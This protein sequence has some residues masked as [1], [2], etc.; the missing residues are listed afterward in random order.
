MKTKRRFFEFRE[1]V[2]QFRRNARFVLV[3]LVAIMV[4]NVFTP[5]ATLATAGE[6]RI[7]VHGEDVDFGE[8]NP[9]FVDGRTYVPYGFFVEILG[10]NVDLPA[11]SM[12]P[13]RSTMENLGHIIEWDSATRTAN[14]RLVAQE[15]ETANDAR[16]SA[17]AFMDRLVVN[18]AMGA[19]L[20]MSA[21]MQ[22][23]FPV[24]MVMF[25]MHGEVIDFTIVDEMQQEDLNIFIIS[26]THTKGA[27]VHS[28]VVDAN[29]EIAGVQVVD[30]SFEPRLPSAN[31]NF[32]AEAI[33]VGEGTEWYLDGLLTIPNGA[34]AQN[35]VPA[36]ILVHG[37]GGQN[38]DTSFFEN[39]P[40]AD[41]A[42]Y[43]S[44]NGI[45][46]LRYNKRTWMHSHGMQA[47]VVFGDDIT[48]W[49][50]TIEDAL[51]AAEILRAD[52]RISEVF[53]VG[54]SMGGLLAPRIAEEGDL[55]G[56]IMLAASPHP[57]FVISYNQNIHFI[58][59]A[60]AAGEISQEIADM[61]IA[62]AYAWLVEAR[63]MIT[64]PIEELAGRYIFHMPALYQRS[65][66]D[67]LP[68]P[69]I[70]GGNRPTLIIHGGRDFQASTEADFLPMVEATEGLAHVITMYFDGINHLLMQSQTDF[71][72]LRD[73][74]VQGNVDE[75][76]LRSMV[77]WIV[78]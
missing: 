49:E 55:D 24:D 73:Y 14:I 71:N 33:V 41:I 48:V 23:V 10:A 40:F 35:P 2:P 7:T 43:L 54:H 34:S 25:G 78:R 16:A 39:R 50:E 57:L 61:H 63:E 15:I 72:D 32:A 17:T 59:E 22:Q 69:I 31:A 4:V 26:A 5:L 18:D 29:G 21:E 53:V 74:H 51:L 75:N 38:M 70:I 11:L 27:A 67:S 76:I 44:S 8:E 45:A 62:A 56:V 68:L 9:M 42:E 20:M 6:I 19:A 30:F 64:W 3:M 60:L 66:Y 47:A 52:E 1:I 58:N 65:I 13:L 12:L 46:V 36:V 28:V 37:S 77:E